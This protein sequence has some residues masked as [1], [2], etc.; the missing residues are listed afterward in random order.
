MEISKKTDYAIRM[1]AELVRND[2]EVI[3]VR[4]AAEK[5]GVPYSF[6]RSIQH[7]LVRA[8]IISS[9]RGSHGGMTL[10]VDP[11]KTTI[12]EIIEAIQGP[13]CVAECNTERLNHEH[14]P[15]KDGCPFM[16]I[17]C[18]AARLLRSYFD[19]VTL[20]QVVIEGRYPTLSDGSEFVVQTSGDC[21]VLAEGTPTEE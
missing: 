15:L 6:G 12:R 3:S 18:E 13:I 8:G 19:A 14:C 7:D 4:Y 20:H 5:N 1:L 2:G 17:W 11:K 16:T 10:A 9:V 21:A